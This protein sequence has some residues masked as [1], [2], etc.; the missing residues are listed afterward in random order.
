MSLLYYSRMRFIQ[1]LTPL[2]TAAPNTAHVISI[3]AGG[4]E[5]SIKPGEI[6]IGTPPPASYGI[7]AVR[8]H[9]AFMKTFFFEELA[10]KHAGKISFTHILPGLVDGPT[11]YS[12]VNPLWSRILWR[13]LKPLVL[14]YMTAPEVCG[15]VMLYLATQRYP[16]KGIVKPGGESKVIGGVAYSTQ[17]EL[18]GGAY[19]VGQ[20]GDEMKAVSYVKVRKIDTA[21]KVWDHTMETLTEIEKKDAAP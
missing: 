13:V 4:F 21:K 9:T 5:D 2:L 3:F 1:N 16:A 14:W 20:R 11:F 18:G 12:D 15:E 17:R 6:P 8:K 19:G 10:E 7:T